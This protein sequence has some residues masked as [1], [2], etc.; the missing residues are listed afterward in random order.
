MEKEIHQ[1]KPQ[2][3]LNHSLYFPFI[4]K[5]YKEKCFV[6]ATTTFYSKLLPSYHKIYQRT[7]EAQK[8]A[9]LVGLPHLFTFDNSVCLSIEVK[10]FFYF[11]LRYSNPVSKYL[12]I[13][14]FNYKFKRVSLEFFKL[15]NIW[16]YVCVGRFVNIFS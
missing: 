5:L 12:S 8:M 14:K 1:E 16:F 9:S 6:V 10:K 11:D 4:I 2:V 15:F 3:F 7:Y 13:R